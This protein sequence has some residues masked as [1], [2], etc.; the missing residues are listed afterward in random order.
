[1]S[2]LLMLYTGVIS[3]G[4]E[5]GRPRV[6]FNRQKAAQLEKQAT[7]RVE[8]FRDEHLAG[9][10]KQPLLPRFGAQE[11]SG[12]GFTFGNQTDERPLEQLGEQAEAAK[13][14]FGKESKQVWPPSDQQQAA[15]EPRGPL[16]NLKQR[17]ERR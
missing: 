1:M 16:S 8:D 13:D 9:D 2:I 17:L 5:N 10:K 4:W 15:G 12:A 11:E 3:V 7:E 14:W 6:S